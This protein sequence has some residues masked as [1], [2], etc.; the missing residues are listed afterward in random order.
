MVSHINTQAGEQVSRRTDS[1]SPQAGPGRVGWHRPVRRA[2]LP[3]PDTPARLPHKRLGTWCS[4]RSQT[5]AFADGCT[6]PTQGLAAERAWQPAGKALTI[7]DHSGR[8]PGLSLVCRTGADATQTRG[9][10]CTNSPPSSLGEVEAEAG[11]RDAQRACPGC[12]GA[13]TGAG[14]LRSPLAGLATERTLALLYLPPLLLGL[15]VQACS[16]AGGTW[17]PRAG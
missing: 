4:G 5:Q 15:W 6:K 2:R 8:G 13:G 12:A 9:A 16:G 11:G 7:P 3:G 1:R 17:S 14:E 10:S